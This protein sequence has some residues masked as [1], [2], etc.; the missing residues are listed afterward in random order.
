MRVKIT[1]AYDGTDFVGWQV[2]D[3]GRSVQSEIEKA[4]FKITGEKVRVTGSGRTDAGVHAAGQVAHFD[5]SSSVPAC[6]FYKALNTVLPP[7]VKVT[8]SEEIS[9]R[10]NACT[11]AKRK[12]YAYSIYL[13]ETENPLYERYS[14]RIDPDI[15][16]ERMKKAAEIFRGEHDFAAFRASGGAAK[17]TV[18]TIYSLDIIEE[19]GKIKFVVCGNGFLYN[20]VRIICG[21]LVAAGKGKLTT[22]EI[23]KAFKTGKRPAL[24][25]TLPAKGLC[26]ESAEYI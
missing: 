4:V 9:A 1:V 21:A 13:S 15:D 20:M 19:S 7:D 16:V 25:K 17:T 26:L 8:A 11:H 14:V 23:E 12:T 24:I 18:R 6:R 10:F 2:Q 22:E 3:N 5:T